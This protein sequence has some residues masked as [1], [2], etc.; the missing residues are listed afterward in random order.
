MN[1]TEL[2]KKGMP[3]RGD[4]SK[5]YY[6]ITAWLDIRYFKMTKDGI[7]GDERTDPRLNIFN[8][9]KT[10]DKL[11]NK[12][13]KYGARLG[14][15]KSKIQN[16]WEIII[17]LC[18][19]QTTNLFFDRFPCF[20]SCRALGDF[21]QGQPCLPFD[22]ETKNKLFIAEEF[23][24]SLAC[25]EI[26]KRQQSLSFWK[27]SR[28]RKEVLLPG[29]NEHHNPGHIYIVKDPD[30]TITKIGKT[31]EK[32]PRDRLRKDCTYAPDAFMVF[33]AYIEDYEETERAIKEKYSDFLYPNINGRREWFQLEDEQV[34]DLVSSL[35]S[36][37]IRF[38]Q[39]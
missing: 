13:F 36:N 16:E 3:A 10:Q 1:Q 5:T 9:W 39:Y 34:E 38:E 29:F 8:R 12:F 30:K 32:D 35:K 33:S 31:K 15:E 17:N 28:T 11:R 18:N 23:A 25:A 22:S 4:R 37:C 2:T 21:K 26:R 19:N 27:T 14:F 7:Q 24:Y 20:E 6:G